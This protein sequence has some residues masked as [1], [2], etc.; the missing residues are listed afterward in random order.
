[1]QTGPIHC[2]FRPQSAAQGQK[3]KGYKHQ[4]AASTA[5][6]HGLRLG[7]LRVCAEPTWTFGRFALEEETVGA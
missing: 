5:L 7:E 3:L 1:M 6:F 4:A 2:S